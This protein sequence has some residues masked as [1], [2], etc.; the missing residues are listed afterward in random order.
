VARIK[1]SSVDSVKAAIDMVELVSAYTQPRKAGARYTARCPFHEERTPSFSIN[2]VDK[3]Y[4]CFGCGVKGD[5]IT[6]VREKE[7]LDF[8]QAIEWL[9]DRFHVPLEYEEISPEVD[10]RRRR[11]ERLHALLEQ[12]ASFYERYLWESAAGEQAREYLQGR[13]LGEEVSRL[14]RLGLAPSGGR[15]LAAKAR[16]QGSTDEEL[17]AAGLLNRRGYDYFRGRLMFPLAD[18]R[19]RIL[20]FQARKLRDDDPLAAKYVNSPEGELFQKGAILYGLDRARAAIAKEDGAIVVEGNTDVL[21]LRQV[22]LERVVASMGTALT[23]RQLK[24]L[25]RLTTHVTLC[26]DGDTAG[27]AATLRGMDLAVAQGL[28]VRVVP[29]PAGV[30]PMDAA[31]RFQQLL[32]RAESYPV[33]RVRL[34]VQREPDRKNAA[35]KV[36]EFLG[37]VPNSV[38]RQDAAQ[39]AEDLLRV[40]PG[41][42]APRALARTGSVSPKLIEAGDRLERYAL[43]GVVVHPGLIPLLAELTP[44]H[45]DLDLHRR[46][47]EHLVSREP[48]DAEVVGALAEL[49]ARAAAEAIDE[50][51]TKQTLLGL[52]ARAIERDLV[53]ARADSKK[54]TELQVALAKIHEAIDAIS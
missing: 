26:F 31:D 35:D 32:D 4:Y 1:D 5:A 16:E 9:A 14:Y 40:P 36:S 53:E 12:A 18:A 10:A 15:T 37:R 48:A 11:G 27:E 54:T 13:G 38:D 21:G 51:G 3:L 22:G 7:G 6:F 17:Q 23:E 29:L 30:D 25:S 19:G 24:E 42:F 52:R 41:T 50:T 8:A 2:A 33:Y 34:E 49:D 46:V 20:G 39:V 28:D 47:R 45:F 43:A 44:D